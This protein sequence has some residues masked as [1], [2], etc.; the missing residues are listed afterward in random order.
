MTDHDRG[1]YTPQTDAPLAFDARHPRGGGGGGSPTVLI[2]SGIVLVLLVAAVVIFY[3]G[4]VRAPNEAP[5]P[6]GVPVGSL[7]GAPP[8]EAQPAASEPPMAVYES[9]EPASGETAFAP[10][11]EQ[12]L[13]RPAARP[14]VNIQ[15]DDLEPAGPPP[16]R[17]T[18][19]VQ[20]RPAPAPVAAQPKPA[21]P[22][23]AQPKPVV[24]PAPAVGGPAVVQIGAFSSEALANQG[25]SDVAGA[26]PGDMAGKGRRVEAV[27]AN[28]AT[29]YR[30]QV[31]GFASREAAAGFCAKLKATG[32]SCIVK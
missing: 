9:G 12:P 24:T 8:P 2:V 5:Q 23:A 17:P 15:T 27:T 4:G 10:A 29:L 11:P 20:P 25:W 19:A 31:T 1:A 22:V 26:F 6:V 18:P 21:G 13:P 30:G 32:K 28:G 3:R 7:K 16:P 14:T